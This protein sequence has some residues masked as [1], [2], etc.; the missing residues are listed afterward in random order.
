ME[1][2]LF[3]ELV[4]L[5]DVLLNITKMKGDFMDIKGDSINVMRKVTLSIFIIGLILNF[6]FIKVS[7]QTNE[8]S[9]NENL[10]NKSYSISNKNNILNDIIFINRTGKWI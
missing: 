1:R 9:S 3:L 7:A 5:I 8:N 10:N 2:I 6:S 4:K